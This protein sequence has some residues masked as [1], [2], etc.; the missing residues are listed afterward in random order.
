MGQETA[1]SSLSGR[2]GRLTAI[3]AGLWLVFALPAYW[4]AGFNGLEG[5]SIAGL[6][7]L[8]PGLLTMFLASL[9]PSDN[10]SNLM[11]T[12]VLG[13]TG[14]RMLFVLVGTMVVNSVRP[15]LGFRGFIVWL[16]AFYLAMLLAETLMV[17]KP[18]N[19]KADLKTSHSQKP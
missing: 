12:T 5:L 17:L 9:M 7:C 2:L 14:L 11:M 19:E 4:L 6:L 8:V 13:G 10:N 18:G 1:T 16:L 3:A 15:Q